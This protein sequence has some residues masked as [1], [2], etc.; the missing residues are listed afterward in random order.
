MKYF[1]L[2]AL[3]SLSL[4][5]IGQ[6]VDNNVDG[7]QFFS[8]VLMTDNI[9]SS[10]L[11]DIKQDLNQ[12]PNVQMARVDLLNKSIFIVTHPLDSYERD[13]FESWIGANATFIDCYRQGLRGVDDF[14]PFD[15][16]FCTNS[17]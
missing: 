4:N 6:S 1:V 11:N 17:E 13:S 7:V 14:I 8:Q 16:N 9:S 12:N 10:E 3:L 15:E 5:G 2:L